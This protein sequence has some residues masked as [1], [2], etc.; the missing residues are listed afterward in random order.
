MNEPP[1]SLAEARDLVASPLWPRI[2]AFL[3]DFASLCDPERLASS[4]T[5]SGGSGVLPRLLSNSPRIARA[6]GRALGLSPFFHLFPATDGS[7]LLLLSREDYDRLAQFLGAV[8]LAPALRRVTAGAEVRALKTAL[9]G[10]YPET[11]AYTAYFRRFEA[12]FASL[13][14]GSGG[15]APRPLQEA[16]PAAGHALL[17]T[18]L[19]S[20]PHVLLLRQRLRFP[21]GSPADQAL[22]ESAGDSAPRPSQ[23]EEAL[24][25]PLLALKLSN[26]SEYNTLCS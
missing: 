6:A 26:P 19:S 11:L 20:L 15:S 8:S 13:S 18:A 22:M 5:P 9:P 7:R 4:F 12:L 16:V 10:I 3:W 1:I 24:A 2:R 14:G 17:A 21:V 25:A 23:A